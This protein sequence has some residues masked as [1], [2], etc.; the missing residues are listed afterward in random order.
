VGGDAGGVLVLPDLMS[1]GSPFGRRHPPSYRRGSRASG[2]QLARGKPSVHRIRRESPGTEELDPGRIV[3]C[4]LT[5]QISRGSCGPISW[6]LSFDVARA[7]LSAPPAPWRQLGTFDLSLT[8]WPR[9]KATSDVTINGRTHALLDRPSMLCHYWG[10]QLPK[11]WLWL[12]AK[13]FDRPELAVEASI[14]RSQAW[15]GVSPCQLSAT[16]GSRT[17]RLRIWSPPRLAALSGSR[18]RPA[19]GVNLSVAG[20]R[21]RWHLQA[22]APGESF[23]DLGEGIAQS[24]RADCLLLIPSGEALAQ[25]VATL[26][27]RDEEWLTSGLPRMDPAHVFAANGSHINTG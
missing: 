7:T 24:R 3:D 15:G 20:L 25:G 17:A 6:D 9:A 1:V 16:P 27:V 23:V 21:G 4:D 11:R 14:L 8:S 18:P 26:E 2:G 5:L 19:G 13:D 22:R 12:S 10:R